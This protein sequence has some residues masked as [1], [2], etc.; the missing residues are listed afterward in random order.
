MI[1]HRRPS[2][3]WLALA[4]LALG[5]FM[6]LLDL[7]IVNVAIPSIVDDLHASLDQILWVLNGYSLMYAVLLI[8]SGRLGDIFGPRNMFAAGIVVFTIAS[9]FS[10]LAQDPTQLILARAL[11]GLGSAV[12]APQSLPLMMSL[13]PVV[14]R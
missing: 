8:T 14:K 4:V 11:Q 3:P 7:T 12:L 5:L 13:F 10:G 6:T 9:A 2:A 1:E